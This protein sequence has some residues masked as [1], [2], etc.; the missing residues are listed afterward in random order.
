MEE[1]KV[2]ILG[3]QCSGKSAIIK[4]LQE[5]TDLACIDHDE[6]IKR[7]HNGKYPDDH[8]YVSNEVLPLIE[9]CILDLP[10]VIYSASFWGLNEEGQISNERVKLAK[11]KGF[12]FVNLITDRNVLTERNNKR[13]SEGKDDA[14]V[15]FDWYQSVYEN[16]KK[17]KQFDFE[18]D[19]NGSVE[20][21]AKD[22]LTFVESI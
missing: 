17:L 14:S 4:Y 13:V 7:R 12:K 18:I 16:M 22:F 10:K 21:S 8:K 6:E 20:K 3:S 19:T 15:S 2:I 9:D 5:N 11:E 1:Y